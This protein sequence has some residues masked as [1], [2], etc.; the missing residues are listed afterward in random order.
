[1]EVFHEGVWASGGVAR[2]GVAFRRLETVLLQNVY[3]VSESLFVRGR[4]KSGKYFRNT[5][6]RDP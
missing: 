4:V 5:R 6:E 2:R 1:M 3:F